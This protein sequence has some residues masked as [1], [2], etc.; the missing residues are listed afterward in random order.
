MN[1]LRIFVLLTLLTLLLIWIGSAIGGSQG[2]MFAFIFSLIMNLGTFWF[3][4][5]IVLA[6]YQAKPVSESQAPRIYNAVRDITKEAKLPMPKIYIIPQRGANA[7]ATGRDPNHAVVAVTEGI[8]S[9]L[10]EEELKG[11]LAHEMAHVKNRDILVGSI[12]ACMAGAVMM[13]ANMARWAAMF[14]GDSRDR[15][16]GGGNAIALLAVSILAPVAALIIQTAISRNREY[17]ADNNGAKFIHNG[18]PLAN[19]LRKLELQ[20]KNQP[21]LANPQSAHMFIINPLSG[22]SI[23]NL[24]STHPP[25]KNRIERLKSLSF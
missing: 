12:A 23:F 19:A 16:R 7:F 13:L 18:T 22:Q 3:S 10:S 11:V 15:N 1:T 6:M 24:F 17:L 20:S 8:V 4:D 9:L 5:K 25:I 21:L 2:A 14:A